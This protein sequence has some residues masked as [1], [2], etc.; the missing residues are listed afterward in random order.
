MTAGYFRGKVDQFLSRLID[1]LMTIP[2]FPLLILLSAYFSPSMSCLG[3]IMGGLGWCP[4]ARIIRSQ[5]LSIVEWNF[6]QGI[7]AMGART[8][9]ILSSYILP[10]VLP[11]AVV[12]FVFGMQAYMLMGVGLGFLG[13]GN[14]DSLDWGQMLNRVYSNG[15]LVLGCWW[16]VFGP[17]IAIVLTSA[18]IAMIGYGLERKLDPVLN[19][20]KRWEAQK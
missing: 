17:I 5:T 14:A 1:V 19:N 9:Y 18:F 11:L 6:V 16:W 8:P 20:Y 3:I 7:R 12:K 13:L 10:F 2:T 15:G 4:C